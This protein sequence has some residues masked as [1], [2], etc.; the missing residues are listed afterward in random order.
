M[1]IVGWSSLTLNQLFLIEE[2]YTLRAM[3]TSS[4]GGH[5]VDCTRRG[6]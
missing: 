1:A 4:R 2:G 5:A 3:A 6:A